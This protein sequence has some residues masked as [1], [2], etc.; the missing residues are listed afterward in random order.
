[1]SNRRPHIAQ[2]LDDS[3]RVMRMISA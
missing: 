2:G 3:L 1:M